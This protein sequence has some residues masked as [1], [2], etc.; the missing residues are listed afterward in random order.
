M[1][2][3]TQI[4]RR[5]LARAARCSGALLLWLSY[6]FLPLSLSSRHSATLIKVC[7]ICGCATIASV[8][9]ICLTGPRPPSHS[10]AIAL[11]GFVF[12]LAIAV[13][14]IVKEMSFAFCGH[15]MNW[16]GFNFRRM[17]LTPCGAVFRELWRPDG[18]WRRLELRAGTITC[19]WTTPYG[20]CHMRVFN[21]L[22][23]ASRKSS[24]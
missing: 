23:P 6:E 11:F 24:I 22:V 13:G 9:R 1:V 16:A 18:T 14:N 21:A 20:E 10:S 3:L 15:F 4:A 5:G 7:R 2:I 19:E 12:L 17:G 8:V